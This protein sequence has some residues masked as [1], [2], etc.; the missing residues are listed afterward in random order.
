[1]SAAAALVAVPEGHRAFRA[2]LEAMANPGRRLALPWPDRPDLALRSVWEVDTAVH[3]VGPTP[4]VG[5]PADVDHAEV[6]LV[7]GAEAGPLVLAAAD[8]GTDERPELGA[9]VVYVAPAAPPLAVRLRGPG[10][11]GTLG[12][13]LP[14]TRSDLEL[15]DQAC[16]DWPRGIDVVLLETGGWV[17]GLPRTTQVERT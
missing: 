6:V 7:G 1:M 14:L 11:D 3:R 13:E 17:R 15:R 5:R 2:L 9:T 8:R 4:D 16:A 10:V 12:C